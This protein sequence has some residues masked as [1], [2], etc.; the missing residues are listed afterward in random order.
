MPQRMRGFTLIELMIVVAIIALLTAIAL[1][2][3]RQYTISAANR[4]CLGEAR[5][6]AQVVAAAISNNFPIPAHTPG[7]CQAV[8]TP[9]ATALTFNALPTTPGDST[10]TCDLVRGGTC[11]L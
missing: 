11:T 8:V 7:R 1:P 2:A 6:Y 10:V 4:A 3:Y 9:A 5:A